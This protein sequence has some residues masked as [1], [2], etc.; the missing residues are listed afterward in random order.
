MVRCTKIAHQTKATR[1][2]VAPEWGDP[3]RMGKHPPPMVICA[4]G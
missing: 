1:W 4:V 2:R 3:A